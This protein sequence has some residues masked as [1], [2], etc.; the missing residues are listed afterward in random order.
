MTHEEEIE[1]G[2]E[3]AQY[4]ADPWRFVMD[5]FPWDNHPE[6]KGAAPEKWQR[7][8]LQAIRD[9]LP[10]EK[11]RIACAS[12]HGVGKTALTSWIILWALATCRDT[13]GVLTASNE[14][15]LYTKNRAEL[16]KWHRLLRGKEFFNLTATALI[17]NDPGHEFTWRLDL[18]PWNP[19]KAEAFAGLHNAG[20][21]ILIIFDEASAIDPIIFETVE[22]A[23]SDIN[24]Q[25]IWC[26][27]G[28]PLHNTGPFRECF[29]KFAH[30]WKRFHVDSR[31]VGISDKEQLARWAADYSEDGY[32]FCTR[33]RGL[34]PAAGSAQFI[35]VD[36]VEEAMAREAQWMPNDALVL[37]VDVAR[38]GEDASV[39]YPR[40]GLDARSLKPIELHGLDTVRVEEQI[41]NF[42]QQHQVDVIFVDDAGAGGAVV[43]H[44]VRHNLP[45]EGVAF[46]GKS[47]GDISRVKHANKRAEMWGT[48]RDKLPY[49]ALP[50]NADLR[51]QLIGP[52]FKFNLKG[53]I[54]LE[55]KEDMRKRGLASPDI[56]DALALTFARPV[57]PRQF[58]N[59]T[60][61]AS[62]VVSDYSPIEEFEREQEGRPRTPQRYY[63]A[64]YPRLL[65]EFE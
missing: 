21:R 29:G 58:E 15:Q 50:D 60:N 2:K 6:L 8:V 37:G 35:P 4:A 52:E 24:T 25:V 31:D 49:L 33:V 56:A 42:C 9:G 61:G 26:C 43:D 62:N 51:D 30:R 46:G 47:V 64:G 57:F 14:A 12:G 32:F 18:L 55:K 48:L 36:L 45:V 38:F 40:R 3:L 28:N 7:E 34:F 44:L 16:T 17:R 10:Q 65:S 5:M 59:W 22:P 63:A 54:Q 1:R 53:E 23:A 41:L 39:L 13:R 11:V 27:F 19:F 20:R